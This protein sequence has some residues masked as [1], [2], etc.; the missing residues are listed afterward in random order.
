[1]TTST[2]IV[3]CDNYDLTITINADGGVARKFEFDGA[4]FVVECRLD[5]WYAEEDTILDMLQEEL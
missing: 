2:Q 4:T 5:E 3:C 1:M